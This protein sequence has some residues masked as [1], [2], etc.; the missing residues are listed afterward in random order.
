MA[1]SSMPLDCGV[2]HTVDWLEFK[3]LASEYLTVSIRD[4][5]RIWDTRRNSED[6]DFEEGQSS[7]EGFLLDIFSEIDSRIAQLGR[8]YPFE[9]SESGSSLQLKGAPNEGMYAY[10]F[11]LL[12]SHTKKGIVLSGVYVPKLTNV[13]RDYFQ[14][15]ATIAA[16]GEVRGHSYSF[17]FPRP[18]GTGFLAKLASIYAA[19]GEGAVV[20][21]VPAG[22][23]LS[24][25]DEQIDV[26]CWRPRRDGAAGKRYI[27]GQVAS[28]ENWVDKTIRGGAIKR[29]HATWFQPP[30]IASQ[31]T[32][33]MFIPFSIVPNPGETVAE[34]ILI[35][36]HEYGDIYY[37]NILP[38]LVQKGTEWASRCAPSYVIERLSDF[39]NV[40][41]WVDAQ[42]LRFRRLAA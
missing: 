24:P 4:L 28:G 29:F 36:S 41:D 21:Q 2:Q 25:K 19:F 22:V 27:L 15:C 14:V 42:L 35:L 5:S 30:G 34:K 20:S 13:V 17:G 37:R 33:A 9:Y 40:R 39:A 6:S 10:I 38:L 32:C 16:A 1:L 12:L 18:N 23:S 7:E 3:V 26:I 8:A 11:C 31:A